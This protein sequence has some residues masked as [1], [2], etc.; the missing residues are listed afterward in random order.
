MKN[1]WTA[2]NMFLNVLSFIQLG[3]FRHYLRATD[4][5]IPHTS[6]RKDTA[7][8]REREDRR[9]SKEKG[10]VVESFEEVLT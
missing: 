10:W 7:R 3:Y 5:G 4:S 6:N 2:L 8:E 9:C 1:G